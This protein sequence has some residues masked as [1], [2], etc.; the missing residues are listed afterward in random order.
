MK[1]M[2]D[3]DFKYLEEKIIWFNKIFSKV[4]SEEGWFI[5]KITVCDPEYFKVKGYSHLII[6]NKIT[7]DA[8]LKFAR[9]YGFDVTEDGCISGFNIDN[10][11][12]NKHLATGSDL[13]LL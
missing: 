11:T 2:K 7:E 1:N 12:R 4:I 3:S 6:L 10:M 13:G 8:A 9:E 5:Y